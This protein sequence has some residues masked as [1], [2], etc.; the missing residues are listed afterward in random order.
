[1]SLQNGARGAEVEKADTEDPLRAEADETGSKKYE[2]EDKPQAEDGKLAGAAGLNESLTPLIVSGKRDRRRTKV[3]E[4]STAM[5]STSRRREQKKGN[6]MA[7]GI[8]PNVSFLLNNSKGRD[9]ELIALH[10]LLFNSVGVAMKRKTNIREFSGFVFDS[11]KDRDRV[12]QRLN[13]ESIGLI[14]K[15]AQ[16]LDLPNVSMTKPALGDAVIAFL[17]D[18]KPGEDRVDLAARAQKKKDE[19]ARKK[20]RKLQGADQAQKSRKGKGKRKRKNTDTDSESGTD[21]GADE[22]HAMVSRVAAGS[23]SKKKR[24]KS[25]SEAILAAEEVDDEDDMDLN[26]DGESDADEIEDEN[27]IDNDHTSDLEDDEDAVEH[28]DEEHGA[29]PSDTKTRIDESEPAKK[30]AR[31]VSNIKSK[32]QAKRVTGKD[33][34]KSQS[35]KTDFAK[36]QRGGKG[37]AVQPDEEEDDDNELEGGMP[38]KKDLDDALTKLLQTGNVEN[39]TVR[40]V[41]TS[42]ESQFG[43]SL[44]SKMSFLRNAVAKKLK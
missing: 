7:L 20:E 16:V 10:R 15:V 8:I 11:D 26:E 3:F 12:K 19:R 25:R 41:R 42:L 17:E 36:N 9:D 13:K 5:P 34:K 37:V 1:M 23:G 2:D 21:G 28:E 32:L 43:C 40:S 18:P 4:A 14:R 29:E 33:E 31:T 35:K 22:D 6:G 27:A 38:S 30:K 39:L 44:Q 24:V